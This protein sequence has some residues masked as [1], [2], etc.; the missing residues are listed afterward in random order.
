[1]KRRKSKTTLWITLATVNILS[2]IYPVNLVHAAKSVDQTRFAAFAVI[3]V[4]L[5]LVVID[6]VS[7][8]LANADTAEERR[9]V[10]V[11]LLITRFRYA[12]I[13]L[14]QMSKNEHRDPLYLFGCHLE[15]HCERNL[16]AYSQLITALD[17]ADCNTRM[18]AEVLLSQT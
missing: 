15:W 8:A 7:I 14:P 5:V 17:H 9:A 16:A 12:G 1:M 18:L 13:E 4:M 11:R 6:A 2:L 10:V 3:G